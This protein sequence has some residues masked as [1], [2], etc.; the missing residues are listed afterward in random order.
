MSLF[1]FI[2]EQSAK[3]AARQDANPDAADEGPTTPRSKI[4]GVQ[5]GGK[6][7]S[8]W[9]KKKVIEENSTIL[10]FTGLSGL[11]QFAQAH[12]FGNPNVIPMYFI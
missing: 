7:L 2:R 1:T 4:G 6:H 11:F 5:K 9:M 10:N 12:N 8:L 3:A